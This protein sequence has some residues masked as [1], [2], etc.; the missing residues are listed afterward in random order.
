MQPKYGFG[1][2]SA[3]NQ[4]YTGP[5]SLA[6]R[7]WV[8]TQCNLPFYSKPTVH[9]HFHAQPLP[10][11][12]IKTSQRPNIVFIQ[13]DALGR[14]AMYR[15]MPRSYKL[16]ASNRYVHFMLNTRHERKLLR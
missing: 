8:Y 5:V 13:F 15:R 16:L 11:V 12:S 2:R 1:R 14:Q 4:N 9:L 10:K 6:N 7:E 3:I